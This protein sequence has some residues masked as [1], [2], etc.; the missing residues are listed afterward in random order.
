MWNVWRQWLVRQMG[1]LR[2]HAIA[3]L[4][5]AVACAIGQAVTLA[6]EPF[7]H[8]T[9]DTP[10]YVEGAL[11]FLHHGEVFS[12]AT[13]PG[14]PLF[15]A[16][17]Y[18][19][20]GEGNNAGV[21]IAQALVL[22]I[23]IGEAYLLTWLLARR[24]WVA[25]LV[26]CVLALDLELLNWERE[27]MTEALALGVA[28][29]ACLAFALA[30]RTGRGRWMIAALV[31]ASVAGLIRPFFMYIPALFALVFAFRTWHMHTWRATWLPLLGGLALAY[32]LV[33]A[34]VVGNAITANYPG[35]TYVGSINLL[36]KIMEYRLQNRASDPQ[37]LAFRADLD[38]YIAQSKQHAIEPWHF[39]LAY[40]QYEA[41]TYAPVAQFDSDVLR[42]ALPRFIL[43]GVPD[44]VR[45]LAAPPYDYAESRNLSGPAQL[46]TS[47]SILLG[48]LYWLAPLLTVA[49][50]TWL[51]ARPRDDRAALVATLAL[52]VLAD[53]LIAG[54]LTYRT[55]LPSG[56]S[57]DEFY[58]MRVPCDAALLVAF[59]GTVAAGVEALL[60]RPKEAPAPE[61]ASVAASPNPEIASDA[62]GE[63]KTG[64]DYREEAGSFTR[65]SSVPPLV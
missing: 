4:M 5:V 48:W 26:G 3:L 38:T 12:T 61:P 14:Y 55:T 59:V 16:L 24:R 52:L 31:W 22:L 65:P 63:M 21:V 56:Q 32:A 40:P 11:R 37:D 50:V 8:L 1:R 33:G 13:T 2:F 19:V 29:T 35:I 18:L 47:Y 42:N 15:L 51:V 25:A 58:R 23:A 6:Q 62:V 17:V 64:G 57:Y 54:M 53:V 60:R 27:I 10:T 20:A 34:L 30:L 44:V 39:T 28:M 45:T 46:L 36:G 41:N 9:P 43:D 49:G 7:V